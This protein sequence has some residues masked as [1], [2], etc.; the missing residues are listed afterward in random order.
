MNGVNK[1]LVNYIEKNVFPNYFKNDKGHQVEHITDVIERSFE[2]SKNL[3]VDNNMV[4]TIA[5]Y[6]D[7]GSYI[8]RKNHEKVSAKIMFEDANLQ[9]FFTEEERIIIKEAI[10]D[11]RASLKGEPRSIY[12]KIVSSA[13]RNIDIDVYI[14]RVYAHTSVYY[15]EYTRDEHL[16]WIYKHMEKKFGPSGYAKMYLEDQLYEDYLKKVISLISEKEK[17]V[18]KFNEV[19]NC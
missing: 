10:E 6:H 13:D 19:I 1:E 5:A 17:F 15:P 16:E 9:E 7:Y 3:N 2:L 14:K 4:Y 12:G 11:H 8:D 18:E